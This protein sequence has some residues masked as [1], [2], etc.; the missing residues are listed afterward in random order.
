[1]IGQTYLTFKTLLMAWHTFAASTDMLGIAATRVLRQ[2][3]CSVISR[4]HRTLQTVSW[5]P[6]NSSWLS[7]F[8]FSHKFFKM[9]SHLN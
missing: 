2:I 3:K 5:H 1:M 7:D 9:L 6:Y 4:S 8:F